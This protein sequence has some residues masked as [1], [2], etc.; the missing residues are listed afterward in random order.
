MLALTRQ[1]AAAILP[2]AGVEVPDE[3]TQTSGQAFS[4]LESY[5]ECLFGQIPLRASLAK[6]RENLS[7]RA[8]RVKQVIGKRAICRLLGP[9]TDVGRNRVVRSTCLLGQ[10]AI[11]AIA[12]VL[13]IAFTDAQNAIA[14]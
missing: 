4:L 7:K 11:L 3:R 12:G 9:F 8:L 10:F 2:A 14:S 13:K 6:S 5:R 1:V